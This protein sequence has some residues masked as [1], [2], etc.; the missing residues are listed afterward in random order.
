MH[1]NV[2]SASSGAA[3]GVRWTWD[4]TS[5]VAACRACRADYGHD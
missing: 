1:G 4:G 5:V 3:R 2:L